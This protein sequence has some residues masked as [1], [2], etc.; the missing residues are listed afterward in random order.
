MIGWT[1]D[2][3]DVT[4]RWMPGSESR[5]LPTTW[6]EE[7]DLVFCLSC[8]RAL[9]GE[10]GIEAAGISMSVEDR[11]RARRA[12]T[13]EFEI[14]R[15]GDRPDRVIATACG[16]SPVVVARARQRLR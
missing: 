4:V 6:I 3:C 5:D 16:T 10:A 2:R 1:C 12:A 14:D 8:R 11:A 9:A 15:D 7:D 13:V